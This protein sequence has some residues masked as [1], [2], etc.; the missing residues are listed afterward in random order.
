MIHHSGPWTDV[1]DKT[2]LEFW[3]D[4]YNMP[5]LAPIAKD[6]LGMSV[7]SCDTERSFSL[8]KHV[9]TDRREKAMEEHVMQMVIMKYAIV[10]SRDFADH[11]ES[12]D[13]SGSV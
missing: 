6:Y 2:P 11:K 10:L 7:S 13:H 4:K 9:V 1:A 5:V 3:E 12:D 8:Y